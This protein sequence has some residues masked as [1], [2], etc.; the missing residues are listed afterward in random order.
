MKKIKLPALCFILVLC[1]GCKHE[2]EGNPFYHLAGTY[3]CIKHISSYGPPPYTDT[4]YY[5]LVEVECAGDD[6][7]KLLSIVISIDTTLCFSGFYYGPYHGISVCFYP[8]SDSIS[9][10][11]MIG[12]LGAGSN[13]TYNGKKTD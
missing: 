4:S 5:E 6:Q 3:V 7:M 13:I 8:L 9:V 2:K 1:L 12:G 11:A 10:Y